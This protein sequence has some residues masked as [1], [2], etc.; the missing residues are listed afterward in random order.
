[1]KTPGVHHVHVENRSDARKLPALSG[2]QIGGL[3]KPLKF[4]SLEPRMS[5]EEIFNELQ[6]QM[7]T[8]ERASIFERPRNFTQGTHIRKAS[9]NGE[10]KPRSQKNSNY[11][12]NEVNESE[13]NPF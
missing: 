12:M 8:Q 5:V 2:R 11:P 9:L 7:E 10:K 13:Q 4:P 6:Y 3:A 1:M